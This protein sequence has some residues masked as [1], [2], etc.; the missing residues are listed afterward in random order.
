[1][2]HGRARAL[3]GLISALLI[4]V[5]LNFLLIAQ[6]AA[7]GD[8]GHQIICQ[9]A[10][11]ELNPEI[12]ARVDALIA[13]DP[14]F[15]TF[16]DACTWP[17]MFPRIRSIEHFLNVPRTDQAVD[18]AHLCP[19]ADRCVASAILNDARDLA[20]STVVNDQLRLLKSPRPLG[21]RHP[22]AVPRIL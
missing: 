16:A 19:V 11:L 1:M 2:F 9:I 6:A 10:Y 5:P 20:F 4:A 8:L 15:R 13:I 18:P 3:L 17:D 14:K 21:G 7:W 12:K 22:S